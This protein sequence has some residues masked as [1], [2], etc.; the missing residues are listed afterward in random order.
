MT[1]LWRFILFLSSLK[2]GLFSLS[3]FFIIVLVGTFAQIEHGIFYTQKV[4]FHSLFIMIPFR[5]IHI[6]VFPGGGLVGSL[7]VL[8]IVGA[9]CFKIQW[10]R[11]KIGLVFVHLGLIVLLLGGGLASCVSYESQV[12]MEEGDSTYFANDLHHNELVI[13]DPSFPRY[14]KIYAIPIKDLISG[15]TISDDTLPFEIHVH[16][17]FDNVLLSLSEIPN[18]A[19]SKGVG[20]G[21]TITSIPE[22]TQDDKKNNEGAIISIHHENK[23]Y[24]RYVVALDID[25]YQEIHINNTIYYIQVRPRRVYFPF[26]MTLKTFTQELYPGSNIPKAYSSLVSIRDFK[27]GSERDVLIYM[28]HP[29]RQDN[30]TFFQASFG[31][32]EPSS[33]LQVVRNPLWLIPYISCI[34]ISLGLLLHFSIYLLAFLKRRKNA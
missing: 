17:Q 14:D 27:M 10:T 19:I 1:L 20:T 31:K 25:G 9:T 13:I 34:I 16:E 30:L 22:F 33:I 7:M 2:F 8:N 18:K 21:L 23:D 5:D 12:Y 6:P 15:Q 3:C 29:Y 11:K 28:N 32:E 26:M 4:Y 24:G